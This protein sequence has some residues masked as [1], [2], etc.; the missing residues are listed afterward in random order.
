[1]QMAFNSERLGTE[2]VFDDHHRMPVPERSFKSTRHYYGEFRP[3]GSTGPIER[4]SHD[5]PLGR[6]DEVFEADFCNRCGIDGNGLDDMHICWSCWE[7]GT[8]VVS[9][10][11]CIDRNE[12]VWLL[13]NAEERHWRCKK[14]RSVFKAVL[15]SNLDSKAYACIESTG[16]RIL[17]SFSKG[18][19]MLS[20][21]GCRSARQY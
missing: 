5:K 8:E 21:S 1:M 20:D 4:F 13:G 15:N 3:A 2:R 6:N 16:Q 14:C 17:F 19:V 10:L 11:S 12:L 18:K 7:H 9:H